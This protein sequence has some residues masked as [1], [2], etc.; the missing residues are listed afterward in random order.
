MLLIIIFLVLLFA[1][2]GGSHADSGWGEEEALGWS[3]RSRSSWG[4]CTCSAGCLD[5]SQDRNGIDGKVLATA[6]RVKG[7]LWGLADRS[8]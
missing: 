1:G 7:S 4:P 5:R 8:S 2:R 3:G 6:L